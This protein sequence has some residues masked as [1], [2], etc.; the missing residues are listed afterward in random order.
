MPKRNAVM[1]KSA[2]GILTVLVTG[3]LELSAIRI[4]LRFTAIN[5]A[6]FLFL[7]IRALRPAGIRIRP[8]TRMA[9]IGL[10]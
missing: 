10:A 3:A 1:A 6:L 2:L 7:G 4:A 5:Y 8:A 9:G